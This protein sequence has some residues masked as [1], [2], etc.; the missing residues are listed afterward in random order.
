M[1]FEL[2]DVFRAQLVGHTVKMASAIRS[3]LELS[4]TPFGDSLGKTASLDL[5]IKQLDS[6]L[7]CQGK[8]NGCVNQYSIPQAEKITERGMEI[9][10]AIGVATSINFEP[11]GA[12][13]AAITVDFVMKA[14]EVNG[15][16]RAR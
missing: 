6:V 8:L 14:S 2:P 5:D 3:A 15:V 10:P 1:G 13:K 9:P 12:G 7:S 4:K 11:T 16:I